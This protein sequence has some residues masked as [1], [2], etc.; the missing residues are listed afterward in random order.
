M[1]ARPTVGGRAATAG[2]RTIKLRSSTRTR[3]RHSPEG[4]SYTGIGVPLTYG[5]FTCKLESTDWFGNDLYTYYV[6]VK[7]NGSETAM[8]HMR[9]WVP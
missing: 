9:V 6:S 4:I 2:T 1:P 7:N 8:Y 5:E 3:S